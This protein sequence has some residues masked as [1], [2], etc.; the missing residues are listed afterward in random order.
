MS[1]K[2]YIDDIYRFNMSKV[3]H[4]ILLLLYILD[5]HFNYTLIQRIGCILKI[6][7]SKVVGCL[8]YLTVCIRLNITCTVNVLGRYVANKKKITRML[9]NEFLDTLQVLII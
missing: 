1:E 4:L 8:M 9:Q 6:L 7:Y 2:R 3:K 5:Y